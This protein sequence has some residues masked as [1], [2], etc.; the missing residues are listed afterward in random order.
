MSN[1][2]LVPSRRSGSRSPV[3][4][5][6]RRDERTGDQSIWTPDHL[7]ACA[8]AY[9]PG[10]ENGPIDPRRSTHVADSP[11]HARLH[12]RQ[13]AGRVREDQLARR[14]HHRR[15]AAPRLR[16]ALHAG[17]ARPHR[18]VRLP[19]RRGAPQ[20]QP[21]PRPRLSLHVF[22]LVE[23]FILPF[24]LDHAR[25]LLAEDDQR[26][27]AFLDSPARRPSTS[28]SSAPSS[29]SSRQASEPTAT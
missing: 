8:E 11:C 23:E 7:T 28:T 6:H 9:L 21:D 22:G 12:L 19:R 24:V 1:G 5:L 27:R 2:Q 25:P 29:A 26:T 4:S 16:Q 13:G 18:R 10:D 17:I 3:A 15:R 14:G 20:A